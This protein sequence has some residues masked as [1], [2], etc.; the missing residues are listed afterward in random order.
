METELRRL[1]GVDKISI[2]IS[3][4]KFDVTFK[5]GAAFRPA[6]IRAAVGKAGVK[7]VRLRIIANGRVQDEAGKRFFLAGADRFLLTGADKLPGGALSI[8]GVVDDHGAPLRLQIV[9]SKPLPAQTVVKT[10]G[11]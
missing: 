7:V 1:D 4:Q 8:E 10:K 9:K 2:S 5:P 6:A 11:G 3:Q